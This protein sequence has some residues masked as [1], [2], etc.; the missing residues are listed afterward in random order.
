MEGP[1]APA[2]A[3]HTGCVAVGCAELVAQVSAM[4][5]APL[6]YPCIPVPPQAT[7]CAHPTLMPVDTLD[8]HVG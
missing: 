3:G 4:P 1:S 5:G 2:E 7:A 6:R 8:R